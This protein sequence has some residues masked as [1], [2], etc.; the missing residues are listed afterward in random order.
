MKNVFIV[1]PFGQKS[2]VDFDRIEAELVRPAIE[3]AGL[4]GGTTGQFIQQGN[5]RTDMFEQLLIADLVIVDMSIH[6][7][8]VFYEMGIRHALRDKRTFLIKSKS[9]QTAPGAGTDSEVPFDL[10]TDR[11]L[12]YDP[13]NPSDAVDILAAAL[14]LTLDSQDAD[15][16]VYQLLPALEP[17]DPNKVLVVP[18]DFRE[19]VARAEA[20]KNCGD[21]QLFAAE[22][23]GFGWRIAGLRMIGH[24]QFRLKDWNGAKVT[25]S[26]VREYDDMDVEANTLLG[27]IFQ[28]LG[29]LVNS[30]QAVERALDNKDIS[31][32]ARAEIRALMGRNAKNQW[33]QS[34]AKLDDIDAAQKTALTSAYLE[35]SF[36]LYRSGFV[37]DRNH[38]YSGLNALAMVTMI[39]EL[40]QRQRPIW[41]DNYENE[42]EAQQKLQKLKDLCND[43]AAGVRLA[44]ESKQTA[45]QRTGKTDMWVDI[46]T[47]DLICLTST[48]PNRVAQAYKKALTDAP[49]QARDAARRQLVLYQRLG[50]LKENIQAGLE[51]IAPVTLPDQDAPPRVILFTGHRLDAPD[52]PTPR[53]PAAKETEAR[54]MIREAV[55]NIQA[56]TSGA[57]LGISGGAS[58]GDI[59]FHEVCEELNIPTQMYLV[60]PRNDYIKASVADGGPDWVERFNRLYDKLKAKVLSDSDRLPRWLR[61]KKDYDLWQRSNLWMLHNALFLSQDHLTLIALWNGATGDGPGGTEDMVK[62]AQDRG[63]QFIHLDARELIL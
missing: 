34:W 32:A 35:K 19:E 23:D 43:L 9:A 38:F 1:R 13:N 6:N 44:I 52:R 46:S 33:E 54:A 41:N 53:F 10:K 56:K 29:D 37:E 14:K 25:W 63:A 11:Y 16:P 58:G 12:S 59:L 39:V 57:L 17:A 24:A 28:R 22:V 60:L 18:I 50:I 26:A 45:L 42:E 27:T 31:A 2:G 7:A 51:S 4:A 20:A 3:Q 15:S 21:L 47:A 8:N 5:I 62:R 55:A 61:G 40:A 48:R 49:D 36:D 30:D